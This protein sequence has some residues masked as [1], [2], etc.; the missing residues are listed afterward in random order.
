MP[1][2]DD[3]CSA[4]YGSFPIMFCP[5]EAPQ[6]RRLMV[7][8]AAESAE[9]RIRSLVLDPWVEGR[10]VFRID[11]GGFFGWEDMI[12]VDRSRIGEIEK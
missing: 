6:G 7:F 3:R 9:S 4:H 11:L 1:V 5:K 2:Q 10:E 8:F 12:S